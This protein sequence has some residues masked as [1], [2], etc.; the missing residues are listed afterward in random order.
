MRYLVSVECAIEFN[1]TF[2]IIKRPAD[3][4][5]GNLL[6]F[7]GGTVDKKDEANPHDV[8]R[9]AVEREIFEEVGLILKDPI[10]Y[11]TTSYFINTAGVPVMHSIFH[12]KLNK[13]S[14]EVKALWDEVSEYYWMTTDQIAQAKNAPEW[15]LRYVRLIENVQG[16]R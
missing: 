4:H 12:C 5:A 9:N 16:N 8:L 1:G 3:R 14:P 2:L 15:L 13:T 7:P 10:D 11:I 6:S